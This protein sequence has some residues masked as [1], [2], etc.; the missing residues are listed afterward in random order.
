MIAEFAAALRDLLAE[1]D[2]RANQ[3]ADIGI[4]WK[5]HEDKAAIAAARQALREWDEKDGAE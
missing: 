4:L 5:K 3:F 1:Y 2:D